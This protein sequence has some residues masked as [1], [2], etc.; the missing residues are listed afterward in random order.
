MKKLNITLL[1]IFATTTIYAGGTFVEPTYETK[2][3][4]FAE[5]AVIDEPVAEEYTEQPV[6]EEYVEQPIEE[7]YV[8]QPVEE[9]VEPV[10]E[11]VEPI[12]EV[13]TKNPATLPPPLPIKDIKTNGLYAGI[14]ITTAKF[15]PNCQNKG[16]GTCVNSGRDRTIGL[17]AR[18]GYD[19]NQYVGVEARGIR[20]NWKYDGGKIKHVGVFV[21]P[22]LPVGEA[23][24][25]YALAGV[26]KTETQGY[27]QH[28]NSKSF[29]WGVGVEH[30]ISEDRAKE[31]RY[32]REFDG[33]GDQEKGLGVFADYERLIQK[34][35][36]PDLDTVNVGLTYDF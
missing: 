25:L 7:E 6:E 21:K 8:E 36:S 13:V 9:Y 4:E 29:A 34:S 16:T 19:V 33:H 14:G 2:D 5:E 10:K 12:K 20:T 32:N 15:V 26:A 3:I 17:M 35:G 24:N 30:D 18:V 28:V 23:T 27:K 31:G 22:M 11:H 1:S